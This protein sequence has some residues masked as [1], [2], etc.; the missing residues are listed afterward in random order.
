MDM[1]GG[2][3]ADVML[4]EIL[5]LGSFC[6]RCETQKRLFECIVGIIRTLGCVSACQDAALAI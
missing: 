5:L 6:R 4:R 3:A 1:V 2:G